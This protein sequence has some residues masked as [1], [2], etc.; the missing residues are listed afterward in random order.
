MSGFWGGDP[1]CRGSGVETPIEILYAGYIFITLL[2]D[3]NPTRTRNKCSPPLNAVC[4]DLMADART[5]AV[6]MF[7]W[8][9]SRHAKYVALERSVTM[10][11]AGVFTVCARLL[12]SRCLCQ[13]SLCL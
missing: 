4:A 13:R 3:K 2:F 1:I 12:R 8:S 7:M 6:H 9:R 10:S 11:S 5:P